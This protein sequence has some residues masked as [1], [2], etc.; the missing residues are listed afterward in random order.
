MGWFAQWSV[1]EDHEEKKKRFPPFSSFLFLD[2]LPLLLLY[3]FLSTFFFTLFGA[4]HWPL[5]SF[6]LPLSLSHTV[7]S[8]KEKETSFCFHFVA[9][10]KEQLQIEIGKLV[11]LKMLQSP[12][13]CFLGFCRQKNASCT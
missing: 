9:L 11:S 4:P 12:T 7:N 3:S 6:S 13:F 2:F 10:I 8:Q 1:E 5:L